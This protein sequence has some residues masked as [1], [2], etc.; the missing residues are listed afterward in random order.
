MVVILRTDLIDSS[1]EPFKN[2]SIKIEDWSLEKAEEY[3]MYL[4]KK[5]FDEMGECHTLE[6]VCEV[7][8]KD[9]VTCEFEKTSNGFVFGWEDNCKGE[10]YKVATMD[11][12]EFKYLPTSEILGY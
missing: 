12:G 7:F 9:D 6:D 8:E 3:I 1:S 5:E 2:E 10:I 11:G 4:Y